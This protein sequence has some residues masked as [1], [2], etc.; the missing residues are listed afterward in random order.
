LIE[1]EAQNYKKALQLWKKLK[2]QNPK[3]APLSVTRTSD[4]NISIISRILDPS[5]YKK[6]IEAYS[7]ATKKQQPKI[8]VYTSYTSGYDILKPHQHIDSRFEYV[9][10]TDDTPN[11]YGLYE[12]KPLPTNHRDGRVSTRYPKTH[13]H[14]LF[15]NHDV[16]IWLDTSI[17]IVDDIYPIIKDF[18]ASGKA[19][20]TTPHTHRAGLFEEFVV[21]MERDKDSYANLKSLYDFYAKIGYKYNNLSENGF[22]LFR[23]QHHNLQTA[24]E[25]WWKMILKYSKR[26]QLSFGYSLAKAGLDWYRI[27][28]PPDNI[29]NNPAFIITPH[30]QSL[31]VIY[32]LEKRLV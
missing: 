22:L 32:E 2:Q 16:A 10:F 19:V 3:T 24:L 14:E 15:P 5:A 26:D 18:I 13:P 30:K 12:V 27:S 17:M 20:G 23:P 21:C 9:V 4:F 7:T 31:D 8:V 11:D 29:N 6:R 25:L 1:T 28:E